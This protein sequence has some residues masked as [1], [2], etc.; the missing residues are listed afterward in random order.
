[1]NSQRLWQHAEDVHRSK[2][3]GISALRGDSGHELP[4]HMMNL[5]P[6]ML[7]KKKFARQW[8]CTPIIPALGRQRQADF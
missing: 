8:W 7:A 5:S 1:M 2:P 4:S 6:I 3:D